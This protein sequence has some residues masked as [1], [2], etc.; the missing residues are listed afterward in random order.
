MKKFLFVGIFLLFVANLFA[1]AQLDSIRA[2][3][4]SSGAKW[5]AG[6]TSMS[7]LSLEK[8]KMRLGWRKEFDPTPEERGMKPTFPPVN[9]TYPESLDW[10]NYNGVNY[11]TP[12]RDQ[13]TCGSCVCFGLL[14]TV[15]GMMNVQAGYENMETD[16]SEQELLSCGPG[17]CNGWNIGDAM[18]FMKYTGVSE[19]KCFPYQANDNIPCSQRCSR[20]VFTKRKSQLWDWAYPYVWGIKDVLLNGPIEVAFDVYQDFMSYTG[21]VYKHTWGNYEGGHAVTMV[22][23]NDADSCW[24]CKNSWGS[25]WGENG[26]FRIAWGQCH[27]ESYGAWL[28]MRPAGYPYLVYVNYIVNDSVGGD[29]DGVLNPGEQAKITIS[30]NNWYG[31]SDASYV[32][33]V[34]RCNDPRISIVDSMGSYGTISAGE[35]KYNVSD[36]YEVLATGSSPVDS[37]LMSLY[38]TAVG[39]SGSYWI[40]FPFSIKYGYMQYGW[41]VISEQVRTSPAVVD[42]NND[43][44]GEVIYGSD[45]GKLYVKNFLG[46]DLANFPYTIANKIWGSPAVG[47]VDNDGDMDIAFPGFNSH[48]YLLE[49]SGNLKWDVTAGG[50][51]I[52]TP[53]LSDL[54]N[55]SH[56]EV[57]VGS[58]DKKLYVIKSDGTPFNDSFPKTL[59]DGSMI[60][61]GCAVG[62]IN[63]DNIKEIIVASYGGYVYALS[64]DGTILPGW[65]FHT[66]GNIW[67]APS[68]ANLVG[69]GVKIAVGSTNDTLYVINADGTLDFKVG[70]SGDVR[71]SP[72]FVD[73][74]G[75]NNLEI[76]F[77]SDDHNVYAYHSTGVALAGWPVNVGSTVRTQVVFSDLNNDNAPEILVA[78]DGGILY[79]F[80]ANGDTFDIFPLTIPGS[81]TTPVVEDV[82]NDGDLDIFFGNINGVSGID[83]KQQRGFGTY[84]NMFRCNPRRTG[85]YGDAVS[86]LK[87]DRQLSPVVVKVYPN[88][89][90]G[91]TKM[92]FYCEK[93]KKVYVSIYNAAGQKVRE[94]TTMGNGGRRILTWD[95]KDRKGNLVPTGVYFCQINIG[96]KKQITQKLIKIE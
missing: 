29:G 60:V 80:E 85:N 7:I 93:G 28:T 58:F 90:K 87:E 27:I 23:W 5:T 17:S 96:G 21:G 64:P 13:G 63:G 50:A 92:F 37:I 94:I 44:K 22:G 6:I 19:E 62:D 40:E 10:R 35:T 86:G 2:A 26:Y 76:F 45:A 73:A 24:I 83:Y 66:G 57:I 56:M 31:W 78:S 41:P 48:I 11:I 75:D 71:S 61:A 69:S 81:P 1:D 34:L 43:N 47:D 20:Y 51:I 4:K 59:P 18:N 91:N 52:A 12:I 36:P 39:D 53:V 33:G 14:G 38:V 88:P 32:D 42:I 77:G 79:A 65:P 89:F 82:D 9:V 70:T 55:D 72:S 67:D 84:W 25:N 95:G 8:Q 49:G 74:D 3:I 46:G 54:D 15:E 68:M 30:I 16:M